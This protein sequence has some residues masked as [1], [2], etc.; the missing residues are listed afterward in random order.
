MESVLPSSDVERPVKEAM[1]S[2]ADREVPRCAAGGAVFR[3]RRGHGRR[4][5]YAFCKCSVFLF[6]FHL[7][8]RFWVGYSR[9]QLVCIWRGLIVMLSILGGLL[10]SQL[11]NRFVFGCTARFF[12]VGS[13]S[14]SLV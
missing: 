10:C 8:C 1:G 3:V 11:A 2:P 4:S 5:G 13:S 9:M 6:L 12:V 7:R 14:C